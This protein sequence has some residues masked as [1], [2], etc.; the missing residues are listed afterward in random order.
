MFHA[1][2]RRFLPLVSPW[3]RLQGLPQLSSTHNHNRG[4]KLYSNG[5]GVLLAIGSV[6]VWVWLMIAGRGLLRVWDIVIVGVAHCVCVELLIGGCGLQDKKYH[7]FV[8]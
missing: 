7:Y 8:C 6:R 5:A 2:V 4:N 3:R 1:T